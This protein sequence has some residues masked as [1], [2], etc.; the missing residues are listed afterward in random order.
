MLAGTGDDRWAPLATGE[1]LVGH[2]DEAQEAADTT[3]P[4]EILRNGTFLVYRKLHENV[5]SFDKF[6]DEA[7]S[8]YAGVTGMPLE[9]ARRILKAKMAG[10]WEDG[11]SIAVAPTIA[12]W[13]AFNAKYAG[14]DIDRPYIDFGYAEDPEGLKC[15]LTSHMRRTNPRDSMDGRSSALI[16][17]RRIL[18]RG[19]PYGDSTKREDGGEHGIIFLAMCASL[20]RQFEFVQQQWIN[21]GMDANAG[22]DTCPLVGN[23]TGDKKFVLPV[24]PDSGQAP[25]LWA[26][27]PKFVEIRGGEYFFL[28]SMTAL[29]M[30]GMGTVDPT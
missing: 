17:R 19:I 5:G 29:R 24:D 2:P 8:R 7:A 10:R 16:N 26:D 22:N 18:R 30:I 3:F 1:F 4:A 27:M 13:Q 9:D 28:P 21:Y 6:I 11:V 15:P 23:R 25:F 12:E 20:T 14:K